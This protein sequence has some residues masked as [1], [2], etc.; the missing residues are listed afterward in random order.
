[1][2]QS[3]R[4]AWLHTAIIAAL[5]ISRRPAALFHPQFWAEDGK[6]FYH[7]AYTLGLPSLWDPAVG[8]LQTLSRLVALFATAFPLFWAP[9]IYAV[10]ALF[11]QLLP[12]MLVLSRRFDPLF[13]HRTGRLLLCYF[14]AAVPN[15]FEWNINLTNAQ[16][17][18]AVA[19]FLTLVAQVSELPACS[20]AELALLLIAGLSGPFAVF[21]APIAWFEHWRQRKPQTLSRAAVISACLLVQGYFLI[22]GM[23]VARAST[24]LGLGLVRFTRIVTYQIFLG[25]LLGQRFMQVW[26]KLPL[27]QSPGLPVGVFLLG[28]LLLVTGFQRG[29]AIYRKALVFAALMFGA[30][31]ASPIVATQTTD[32][33]GM[34]DLGN[35]QRYYVFPILVWFSALLINL[36]ARFPPIR[37]LAIGFIVLAPVGIYFDWRHDRFFPTGFTE[38]AKNFAASAPGTTMTFPENPQGWAMVLVKR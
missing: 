4:L 37:A 32:W 9:A 14:Y 30:A 7:D 31:L 18:A 21:L 10:A 1:M 17:H 11:F 28:A 33:Q 38:L 35:G 26:L 24:P 29:P 15:S 13:P 2:T 36:N 25:G 23:F 6:L 5:M 8:Y 20:I 22:G 12:V 3:R 16:W 34:L 27:W 19:A